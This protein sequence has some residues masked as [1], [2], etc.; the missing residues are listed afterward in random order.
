MTATI[1]LTLPVVVTPSHQTPLLIS[2]LTLIRDIKVFVTK[3]QPNCI[4]V[5]PH[6]SVN[7]YIKVPGEKCGPVVEMTPAASLPR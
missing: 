6:E 2:S 3:V 4:Y 7:G 1:T 5:K